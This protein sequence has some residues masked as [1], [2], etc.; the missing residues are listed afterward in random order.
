M[1][2]AKRGRGLGGHEVV[3]LPHGLG[4]DPSRCARPRAGRIQCRLRRSAMPARTLFGPTAA[5]PLC[6]IAATGPGPTAG[7]EIGVRVDEVEDFS[8]AA[9][10]KPGQPPTGHAV[11]ECGGDK[12]RQLSGAGRCPV[13]SPSAGGYVR[14]RKA[15]LANGPGKLASDANR[16][17]PARIQSSGP[18]RYRNVCTFALRHQLR[19][20]DAG[21]DGRA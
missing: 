13:F 8:R 9:A 6:S 3:A 10:G 14:L 15:Q 20:S 16:S 21:R 11:K 5:T 19:D 12:S 1:H 17:N 4:Q 2:Q 18:G 7:R